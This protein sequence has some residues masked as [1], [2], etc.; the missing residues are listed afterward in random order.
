MKHSTN[1]GIAL[2]AMQSSLSVLLDSIFSRFNVVKNH[3]NINLS[4]HNVEVNYCNS[5][6]HNNYN[7]PLHT[8]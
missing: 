2:E 3:E 5:G 7:E 4:H 8:Y 6:I 1:F